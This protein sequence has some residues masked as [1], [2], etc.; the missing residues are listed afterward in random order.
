M[1]SREQFVWSLKHSPHVLIPS[2]CFYI[3]TPFLQILSVTLSCSES[4]S[5]DFL[6]AFPKYHPVFGPRLPPHFLRPSLPNFFPLINQTNCLSPC[7]PLIF[8]QDLGGFVEGEDNSQAWMQ[9][10]RTSVLFTLQLCLSKG[11]QDP[12]ASPML[13]PLVLEQYCVSGLGPRGWTTWGSSAPGTTVT[14]RDTYRP[15]RE[16]G[17]RVQEWK[18][19]YKRQHWCP[20]L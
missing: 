3:P 7:S 13:Q 11:P 5:A 14:F 9:L 19:L 6:L 4:H 12:P 20:G 16:L 8:P 2:G 10:Y 15:I 18:P 1:L 17:T